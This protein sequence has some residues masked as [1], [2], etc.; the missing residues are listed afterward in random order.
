MI[1]GA[2]LWAVGFD[3]MKRADQVR[4]EVRWLGEKHCLELLDS[5]VVVR[6]HDGSV[7]LNGESFVAPIHFSGH[8]FAGFLAGLML[9]VPPLSAAAVGAVAQEAG[10]AV[11][12]TG[13]DMDFVNE[14]QALLKPGTSALFI[15]DRVGND[16]ALLQG[17]RGFGGTVLKTNVDP[18]RTR[19]IQAT[20]SALAEGGGAAAH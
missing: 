11:G 1:K 10:D 20:M 16:T 13:I 7:T 19:L 15:L 8:L 17:I 18:E 5:A 9:A 3:D 12:E 14:V 2:H 6:Y 4:A